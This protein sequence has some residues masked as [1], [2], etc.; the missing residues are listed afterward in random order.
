MIVAYAQ[1]ADRQGLDAAVDGEAVRA[2]EPRFAGIRE[3][4]VALNLAKSP[5]HVGDAE[6]RFGN[7]IVRVELAGTDDPQ[8]NLSPIVV[9]ADAV[10]L[11]R[12]HPET[13]AR[14]VASVDALGRACDLTALEAG[15]AAGERAYRSSR[16]KRRIA[17]AA[18]VT[19]LTVAVIWVARSCAASGDVISS[20]SSWSR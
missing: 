6:V 10:D 1:A 17:I 15:F 18:A 14:A 13:M 12:G 8:G 5:V 16:A 9:V 11:S 20:A 4:A 2:D 19:L 3:K 7:G